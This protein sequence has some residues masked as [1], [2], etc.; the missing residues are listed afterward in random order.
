LQVFTTFSSEMGADS[1]NRSTHLRAFTAYIKSPLAA[2]KAA[3]FTLM[4]ADI[5]R[6][7]KPPRA[8]K[9]D[10]CLRAIENPEF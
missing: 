7:V 1:V 9:V 4:A 6:P 5:A 10:L 2:Y 8:K 3:L